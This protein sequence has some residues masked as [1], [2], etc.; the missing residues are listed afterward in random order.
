MLCARAR[1][2]TYEM[3]AEPQ[4]ASARHALLSARLLL[5]CCFDWQLRALECCLSAVA[6][7]RRF[8]M[9]L[10]PAALHDDATAATPHTHTSNR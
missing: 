8:A 7:A 9:L 6:A 1:T 3:I 2:H 10:S 4:H 5:G